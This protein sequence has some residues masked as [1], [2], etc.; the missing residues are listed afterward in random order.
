MKLRLRLRERGS[1]YNISST[2]GE[3]TLQNSRMLSVEN[4][5]DLSDSHRIHAE[6]S[7]GNFNSRIH[8]KSKK[9]TPTPARQ[10]RLQGII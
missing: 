2:S 7:C 3:P 6:F 5:C 4:F 8:V 1:M 10:E 9:S